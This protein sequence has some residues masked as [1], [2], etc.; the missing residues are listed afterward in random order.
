M[1]ASPRPRSDAV[2]L[3]NSELVQ[4]TVSAL[5]LGACALGTAYSGGLAFI[6]L[7][8]AAGAV[9]AFEWASV[10]RLSPR[11]MLQGLGAGGVFLT[12][13][14]AGL[15]HGLFV[16]GLLAL[17]AAA[18][19][20]VAGGT[21]DR[22]WAVV[23]IAYAA[24]IA[25][26]PI[27]ARDSFGLPAILWMFAVVWATDVAAYVVGRGLGGPKLWPRISPRKTWSGFVAGVV[28]GVAGGYATL[29][30]LAAETPAGAVLL[31]GA[32]ASVGA[33]A[34]DLAES[35]LKRYFGVKDSGRLI[36]GHGG[37]MDRLDGFWVV[38]LLMGLGL[39]VHFTFM[40]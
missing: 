11:T 29:A 7:W 33:Q 3:V 36:P 31:A 35:A 18:A 14:A 10:T 38:S 9:I 32:V 37:F 4:R 26:V 20:F 15:G 13:I 40:R 23:G 34:G 5:L 12:G 24:V 19:V 39:V 25:V 21:R 6:V 28:A 22:L 16:L 30:V 8:A 2:P 27:L 1:N 17:T